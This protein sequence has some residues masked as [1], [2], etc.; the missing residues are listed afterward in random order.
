MEAAT[1]IGEE[2]EH[3]HEPLPARLPKGFAIGGCVVDGWLRDGGM[4][5]I[6][7]ARRTLDD[8][9]VALKLQLPSSAGDAA[10]CM[11]FDREAEVMARAN[12]SS[13]VVEL[14]DAGKLD[15]GRRFFVMEW[16]EGE[17]LEEVL[18]F[19]RNQDQ[20]LPLVRACKLGRDVAR[21]LV[22]L[23]EHGVLHLDLKPANVMV[24]QGDAG[25]EVKLVDF[26]IAADLNEVGA[27][28]GVE[29]DE[30]VMGTRGYMAPEQVQ[31]AAANPSFDVYALGVVLFEALTGNTVP[32]GGWSAETL[33]RLEKLRRGVPGALAELV[34]ACMDFDPGRRPA[35]AA[36][37]MTELVRVIAGLESGGRENRGRVDDVMVRSG[38]TEIVPPAS[39]SRGGAVVQMPART[40]GTE[41]M[42]HEEVL[43]RSGLAV[44]KEMVAAARQRVREKEERQ[45][46][47]KRGWWV[48]MGGV[49]ALMGAVVVVVVGLR[50]GG[51]QEVGSGDAAAGRVAMAG[52]KDLGVAEDP[53]LRQEQ[54]L[55]LPQEQESVPPRKPAT[56][57]MGASVEAEAEIDRDATK[58]VEH[59]EMLETSEDVEP[60]VPATQPVG[61]QAGGGPSSDACKKTR[62][63][64][65]KAKKDR[66]WRKVLK[67]TGTRG[68]WTNAAQKLE[69]KRLR[70]E[71]Y[72][73]LGEFGKCADEGEHGSDP[74]IAPR[75]KFCLKKRGAAG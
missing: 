13:H 36:V 30:S 6:Y 72:A 57:R 10:I 47:A 62:A 31:G 5:A 34:R 12:G 52:G 4:A 29:Q 71:A 3:E 20:R 61:G 49:G 37:V 74:Q 7:R 44:S 15:D 28:E 53:M 9:R 64:A 23:H 70:V 27:E 33:P 59:G 60:S 58:G 8:R 35:S 50:G 68:C 65:T 41:L 17:N 43:S 54:E 2:H 11:R 45:R 66:M 48:A 73:E 22:E 24:A 67:E 19:L 75:V 55:M 25:D 16:V 51:E 69:R 46:R 32:P 63:E 56:S 18:D 21:G 1:S 42:T 39:V 40:G 26:G 38:G 14:Y